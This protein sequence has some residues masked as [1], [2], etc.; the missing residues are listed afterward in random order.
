M[1]LNTRMRSCRFLLLS[2]LWPVILLLPAVITTG[3][4]R[5]EADPAL[6]ELESML[7]NREEYYTSK[8]KAIVRGR[9]SLAKEIADTDRYNVYRSLFSAY[10]N[11]DAD[12]A[13][14]VALR[15]Q[16]LAR[17]IGD[18]RRSV[19]ASL[20]LAESLIATGEYS[21][22]LAIIDTIDRAG[23]TDYQR[24]Y[25]YNLYVSAY[26]R[27]SRAE[28]K[29]KHRVSYR[30]VA[31]AYRDS[32]IAVTEPESLDYLFLKAGQLQEAGLHKEAYVMM[33][34]ALDKFGD[35]ARSP[36]MLDL[37]GRIHVDL[38]NDREAIN[39]L[40]EAS[41]KYIASGQRDYPSLM[42][43]SVVLSRNGDSG[44]AY[45]Y[46]DTALKDALAGNARLR[47]SEI[48]EQLPLVSRASAEAEK[49]HYITLRTRMVLILCLGGGLLL[50]LAM[51]LIELRRRRETARALA[52]ANDRLLVLN[53]SLKKSNMTLE[54]DRDLRSRYINSILDTYSRYIERI[55]SYRKK[56]RRMLTTS[57][58][59]A[60]MELL[61]SRGI[62][63]EEVKELT[64]Y[65]DRMFL[66]L[67][68][69]FI[70][71]Y[72]RMVPE[73]ER[74]QKETQ[75]LTAKVRVLAMMAAGIGDQRKIATILHYSPQ[76][77]YNYCSQIR[78]VIEIPFEDFVE[79]LIG[80]DVSGKKG[81]E[82]K[83]EA[84]RKE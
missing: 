14:Y 72:N 20:N 58:P 61:D 19:S 54:G 13:L 25:L 15:R 65:F 40:T 12:S 26:E 47:V 23:F 69:E 41:E 28:S 64:R 30:E 9:A 79:S 63:T 48:Q 5:D 35:K 42:T 22:G 39:V 45:R 44:R 10:R 2:S 70:D 29:K 52:E 27:L 56:L 31:M 62:V 34:G 80:G 76:T 51:L 1:K 46:I 66:D 49:E 11:Y 6:A 68:P 16:E 4:G 50:S 38:G 8:R 3:C 60:A 33:M 32:A 7:A 67:Y 37:L 77:I 36:Q 84:S 21:A 18:R 59:G 43:L 73:K 81:F 75:T 78:N 17:V 83:S 82:G 55:E 74:L 24:M 57:Q 53:N 71:N